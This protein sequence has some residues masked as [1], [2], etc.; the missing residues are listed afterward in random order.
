MT[1][2]QVKTFVVAMVFRISFFESGDI[3]YGVSGV[4]KL[5]EPKRGRASYCVEENIKYESQQVLRN[6][7]TECRPCDKMRSSEV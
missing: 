1:S 4:V 5:A 2:A 3:A 7:L 6:H